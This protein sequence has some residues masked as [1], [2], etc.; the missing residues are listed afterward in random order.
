MEPSLLMS[1]EPVPSSILVPQNVHLYCA[2]ILP[3]LLV[4]SFFA[5]LAVSSSMSMSPTCIGPMQFRAMIRPLSRPSSTRQL[6]CMA[7][8]CIP[9]FPTISRT[10]AGNPSSSSATYTTYFNAATF[11]TRSSMIDFALPPLTIAAAPAP[12]PSPHAAPSS[13]WLFTYRYGIF[14]SS[15]SG[16]R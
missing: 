11:S 14:F 2:I 1:M 16:V 8:P 15:E 6:T 12:M 13:F 3:Y 4:E 5:S 10:S 7:S 9:V